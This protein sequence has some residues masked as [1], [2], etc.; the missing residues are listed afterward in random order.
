VS[1][2]ILQ[3]TKVKKEQFNLFKE[4]NRGAAAIFETTGHFFYVFAMSR[5]AIIVAPLIA[6]YSIFSVPKKRRKHV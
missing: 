6:S 3:S 5:N 2:F 1:N 4:R